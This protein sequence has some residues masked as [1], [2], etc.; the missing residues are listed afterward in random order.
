MFNPK[1]MPSFT[2]I[3]NTSMYMRIGA[4]GGNIT[5]A[6][7]SA[8]PYGN[9]VNSRWVEERVA[10]LLNEIFFLRNLHFFQYSLWIH[11]STGFS[12]SLKEPALFT[13]SEKWDRCRGKFIEQAARGGGGKV[14]LFKFNKTEKKTSQFGGNKQ[15]FML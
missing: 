12:A 5:V 7:T 8:H 1:W 2:G 10:Q 4:E 9:N 3:T 6:H 13:S 15:K 14:N 11:D